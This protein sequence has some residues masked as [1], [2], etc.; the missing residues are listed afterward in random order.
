MCVWVK[1]PKELFALMMMP[2][3]H[4]GPGSIGTRALF[5]RA[6]AHLPLPPALHAGDA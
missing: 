5:F 2:N 3:L 4:R 6:A 1:I